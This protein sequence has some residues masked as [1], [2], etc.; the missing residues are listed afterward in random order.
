MELFLNLLWVLLTGLMIGQW[1]RHA[2]HAGR[3]RRVQMI[4]LAMLLLLLFPVI[5]VTDDLQAALNPA[6]ADCCQRRDHRCVSP[7]S[8]P[9]PL[10]TLPPAILASPSFGLIRMASTDRQQVPAVAHPELGPIQNRPPPAA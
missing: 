4:A 3:D 5:S 6:E 9:P 8:I 10:A 1:M 7:H 2:P